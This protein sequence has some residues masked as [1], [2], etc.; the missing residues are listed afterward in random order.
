MSVS[1]QRDVHGEIWDMPVLKETQSCSQTPQMC[2]PERVVNTPHIGPQ[3]DQPDSNIQTNLPFSWEVSRAVFVKEEEEEEKGK[4]EE[5]QKENKKRTC[6][7]WLACGT[8][9]PANPN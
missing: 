9:T 7:G 8:T 3:R 5:K 6:Q 4:R 2:I 1:A